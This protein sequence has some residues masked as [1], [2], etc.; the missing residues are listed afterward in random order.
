MDRLQQLNINSFNCRGLRDKKKRLNIFK[1]LKKDHPG[2]TLLQETHSTEADEKIW[3]NEWGGQIYFSH[4]KS[5]KRG[6]AVL[7]PNELNLEFSYIDGIRDQDGRIFLIQCEVEKLP[8]TII[9]VYA[10]TKDKQES[11]LEF[12]E[13]LTCLISDYSDK[14][15]IIGGDFNVCLDPDKDKKGGNKENV[16]IYGTKILNILEEFSLTDI[17]RM[18]NQ[19]NLQ[20]SRR[21]RT[22]SGVIHSR[23]D[24]WLISRNLEYQTS[25]VKI[26]PGNSSD[27]SLINLSL[28]IH[29]TQKR[30]KGIWK[31]NNNLLK[32]KDYVDTIKNQINMI[33]S[34]V[35]FDNKNTRWDYLKCQIRTDTIIYASK[36]A[37]SMRQAEK[38]LKEKVEHLER[39]LPSSDDYYLDYL[40][41]KLEL[42][43]LLKVKSNGAMLRSKA[44]WMEYGEKNSKYFLNLEKRNYNTK[45]IKK[46]ILPNNDEVTN[47]NLILDEERKFYKKLYTST[48]DGGDSSGIETTFLP[49]LSI[50]KLDHYD[51]EFCDSDL[52]IDECAK[53]LKDMPNDK[54][55]G[56]DGLTTNFYKFF[57]PDIKDLLFDSY[58]YSFKNGIL[59]PDQRRAVINLIPK[60]DKDLRHLKNWRPVSL[61]NTDYKILTK[62]L[63]N[64]LQQVISKLIHSDQVGYIHGRFI[65]ENIRTISNLMTYTSL[66]KIPSLIA[67]VDFEKAFDTIE[68]S[69]LFESLQRYN[70]GD[71]FI[72]WIKTLYTDISSCTGN[73]GYF[74]RYFNLS[75]GLRQGCSISA[76]LFILVAEILAIAIRSNKNINGIKV[77]DKIFKINLLADDTTLFLADFTS[78][79]AAISLFDTF[80]LCS[81]LKINIEKTE[82]IPLGNLTV[83]NICLTKRLKKIKITSK[84]FKTL[85]I[86]FS[87][88][89]LEMIELNFLE[90]LKS[91][92]K[93]ANIWSSRKLSWKGKITII[94]THL[95]SQIRHLLTVLYVPDYILKEFESIYFTFLWSGKPARIK[96]ASIIANIESGG[97]KMPDIYSIHETSKI[98]WVKKLL[99]GGEQN[100]K[101]LEW[102]LMNISPNKIN[103]KLDKNI[104]EFAQTHFHKQVL[105]IWFSNFSQPPITTQEILNEYLFEN[106]FIRHG[107]T[108]LKPNILKQHIDHNVKIYDIVNKEGKILSRKDLNKHLNW[109]LEKMEYNILIS[110][111]PK[112]WCTKLKLSNTLSSL[113]VSR[114]DSVPKLRINNSLKS[115]TL[116]TSKH[117]YMELVN[118]ISKPITSLDTWIDIYPFLETVDWKKIFSLPYQIVREPY[119]QT[120]QYKII[121]RTLNCNSN[122]YKWGI[123]E[124]PHCHYC[125]QYDTLEHHLFYCNESQKF[126]EKLKHWIFKTL[127]LKFNFTIC[128]ILLGINDFTPDLKLI[129]FLILL[130]KW[131][132]N[133]RKSSNLLILFFEFLLLLKDKLETI[134]AAYNLTGNY[135][136]F[137]STYDRLLKEL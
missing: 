55:P 73:N 61:L 131:Y 50:P 97:L 69:F 79:E 63:S 62:T 46:L 68:W 115:I 124:S 102:K 70:F 98:M 56:S 33:K 25:S 109:S 96:K 129:N 90:R 116:L 21:E 31:F 16:S 48:L 13:N 93:I 29:E 82:V 75:R 130:G 20:F 100:W 136:K 134:K 3:K 11:Q 53:A 111:I 127:E 74:S 86:W 59:S 2:I 117:I 66:N 125:N 44:K 40:Q 123:R 101:Y 89:H 78:L 104:S 80:A 114:I 38:E 126:W 118:K 121:N 67:L 19:D 107:K 81:G 133:D 5:N 8:L 92:K 4:G 84:P 42:E 12:L 132:L 45:Y 112:M 135:I 87:H 77:D 27:H 65:G 32:D 30:G 17:W 15:I 83:E 64:R 122:L 106:R 39:N 119:I 23:L 108:Y 51:K 110:S 1:W 52:N 26:Q 60:K 6:V 10:P 58:C 137:Q 54:S 49:K 47:P 71:S 88:N 14:N 120:F 105:E 95:I 24:F 37:K 36:K 128:E 41:A 113:N 43:N 9:N 18:R 34:S 103:K 72:G 28:E 35:H 85:G 94:K 99:S 7:I 22:K 76:L 57:W 91:T